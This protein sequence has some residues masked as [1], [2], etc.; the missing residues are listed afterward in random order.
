MFPEGNDK[1]FKN[2]L[3]SLE[4]T[5]LSVSTIDCANRSSLKAHSNYEGTVLYSAHKNYN[6]H[7]LIKLIRR[8]MQSLNSFIP[9]TDRCIFPVSECRRGLFCTAR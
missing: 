4:I 2:E 9:F 6:K 7:D 3:Y 1:T 8:S 5:S